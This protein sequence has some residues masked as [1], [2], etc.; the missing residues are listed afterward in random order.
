[1][2]QRNTIIWDWNGTLLDDAELCR[3]AINTMLKERH[4]PELSLEKYRSV[5]TFPVIEYYIEVGF[6]FTIEEWDPV[7][8]EFIR[9]YADALPGCRLT[10]FA[11]ETLEIF[12]QKGY[13]QAIISAMEHDSL[14]KSVSH[15]GIDHYFDHIGGIGDHYASSKVD[16]ARSYFTSAGLNPDRITLIGDTIHDSEVAAELQCKCI[17]VTTGHQSFSRL[18]ATGLPVITDLSEIKPGL[19]S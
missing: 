19:L 1:M 5:F 15:L 4:L 10:P 2:P 6:D 14:L 18:Q 9:Q 13:R 8:M 12:K 16:N 7:A 3:K 17:L 11:V